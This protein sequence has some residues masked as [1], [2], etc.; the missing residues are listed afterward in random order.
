MKIASK[1]LKLAAAIV[2]VVAGA[3]QTTKAGP[4]VTFYTSQASFDAATSGL[5]TIDFEGI[6]PDNTISPILN[7]QVI[8]GVT[9]TSS[10]GLYV[11][12]A[13][14]GTAGSPYES[15]VLNTNFNAPLTADVTTVGTNFTAIG[16]DFDS[17]V[18]PGSTMVITLTGTTGVLD[19]ETVTTGTLGVSGPLLFFGWTVSGDT[20]VNVTSSQVDP[21]PGLDNFQY[22][23]AGTAVPEP[24]SIV[25]GSIATLAGLGYFWRRRNAKASV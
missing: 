2:C 7:T 16:G 18:A 14:S 23:F 15:A 13:N 17:L 10:G 24:S 25:S 1:F 5:T 20:V 22:G 19:T 6:V 12:G 11:S 8:G 4:T 3:A 21:W 9:F